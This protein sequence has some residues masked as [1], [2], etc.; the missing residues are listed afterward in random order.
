MDALTIISLVAGIVSIV[1]AVVAMVTA[2]MSEKRSQAS[3]EKTQEMARKHYDD[4]QKMMQ[5]IYDK[6]KDALAEID[7]KSTVIESVVQR[8]QEQLLGTMTNLLNETIIPKKADMGEQLGMQF[9]QSL[10]QNPTN[11]TESMKMLME[12][13]DKFGKDKK[14]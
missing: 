8:N 9:M 13:S 3:F 7:K 4:T 6:T 11:A 12:L 2:S 10:M 5:E 14:E 1:L